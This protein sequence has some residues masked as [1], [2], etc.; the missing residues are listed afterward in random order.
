MVGELQHL[1]ER[2]TAE[3]EA[4][5]GLPGNDDQMWVCGF[6]GRRRRSRAEPAMLCAPTVATMLIVKAVSHGDEVAI[7]SVAQ[8]CE[9]G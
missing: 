5:A 6:T 1:I 4:E 3:L 8:G 9:D 7:P 2:R